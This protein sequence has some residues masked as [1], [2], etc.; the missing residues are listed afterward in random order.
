[1]TTPINPSFQSIEPLV[2]AIPD[3]SNWYEN[4]V[5][6]NVP[7][8]VAPSML[9]AGYEIGLVNSVIVG[10]DVFNPIYGY[11]YGMTRTELV[12]DKVLADLLTTFTVAYNEGRDH[13][14][15]RYE[16]GLAIYE[17]MLDKTQS[18]I[19]DN[20]TDLE[21]ELSEHRSE[22]AD[23]QS[24]YDDRFAEINADM[25]NLAATLEADRTRVN[26]QYDVEESNALTALTNMG[27]AN[28]SQRTVMLAGIERER[29]VALTEV[30]EREQRLKAEISQRKN[31]VY[32]SAL[33]M[34][35]DRLQAEMGLQNREQEFR[36]YEL[37]T[38]NE[39]LVGMTN[40]VA[41]RE[42][43]HPSL[44]AI[45]QVAAALAE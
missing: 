12:G 9:A 14:H 30:S 7:E 15:K 22:L 35:V 18:A 17:E 26:R 13:N 31:E 27:F 32:L 8:H 36:A 38:R 20:R 10:G 40:F 11:T 29:Q 6:N 33:R 3:P 25:T 21:A 34:K 2:A 39:I 44:G 5:A 42:D 23:L 1:M 37:G 19:A 45:A 28:S 41:S 24:D 4:D 43:G 16:D